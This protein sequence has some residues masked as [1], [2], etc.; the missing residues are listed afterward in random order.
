MT[1]LER[2]AA[3]SALLCFASLVVS[4]ALHCIDEIDESDDKVFIMAGIAGTLLFTT[5]VACLA[6]VWQ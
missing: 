5:F 4:A 3:T 2:L 1:L 6:G